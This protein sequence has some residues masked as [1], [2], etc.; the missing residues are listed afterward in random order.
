M[1]ARDNR[2]REGYGSQESKGREVGEKCEKLIFLVH[3]CVKFFQKQEITQN[4]FDLHLT[5][6]QLLLRL[7]SKRG[8]EN[9]RLG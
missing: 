5:S 9:L 2:G 7:L 8:N 6:S 1:G 4:I 3:Q